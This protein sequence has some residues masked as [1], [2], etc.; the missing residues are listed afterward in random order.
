V[1]HGATLRLNLTTPEDLMGARP[2]GRSAPSSLRAVA[3]GRD[4]I[5]AADDLRR[6]VLSRVAPG[7]P[8]ENVETGMRRIANE[9]LRH[10]RTAFLEATTLS[11]LADRFD[12]ARASD[13]SAATTGKWHA[14]LAEQADRVTRAV[15]QMRTLLEPIF[16]TYEERTALRSQPAAGA[17]AAAPPAENRLGPGGEAPGGEAR[18]IN[19]EL[20]QAEHDTRAALAVAEVAPATIELRERTFWRRLA[21]TSERIVA[22]R[23]QLMAR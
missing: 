15:D 18:R 16:L 21:A 10:A 11:T 22:L 20:R 6:A 23:Q 9:G 17:P 12:A 3:L 7:V 1:P 2:A 14:L 4:A 8:I 19:E 13:M 5:P